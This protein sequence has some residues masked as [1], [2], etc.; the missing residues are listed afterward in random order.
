MALDLENDE[1]FSAAVEGLPKIVELITNVPEE[2]RSFALAVAKQSYRET[3]QSMGYDETDAEQWA[4]TV[5][6]LFEIASLASER[7]TAPGLI[8]EIDGYA[9]TRHS[10]R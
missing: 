10:E 4:S 1:V 7:V 2:K 9:P 8:L 3:A 6:S 5:M